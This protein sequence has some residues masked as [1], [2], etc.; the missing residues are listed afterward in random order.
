MGEPASP[1][2]TWEAA[3]VGPPSGTVTFAFT[4]V[5]ASTRLWEVAPDAMRVA[6]VRHDEIVQAVDR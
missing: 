2:V 5:V 6:L 4:D 3:G 1:A